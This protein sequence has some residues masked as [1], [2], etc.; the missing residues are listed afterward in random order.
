MSHNVSYL[1]EL[2]LPFSVSGRALPRT[3]RDGAPPA[4]PR[5]TSSFARIR[6]EVLSGSELMFPGSVSGRHCSAGDDGRH[7]ARER[8]SNFFVSSLPCDGTGDATGRLT[9]PLASRPVM[10]GRLP[11]ASAA[12]LTAR[13]CERSDALKARGISSSPF[14]RDTGRVG[15]THRLGV[16]RLCQRRKPSSE[17]S[18]PAQAGAPKLH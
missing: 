10:A 5:S 16:V 14:G 6:S 15:F 1:S 17:E 3:G 12:G 18:L 2:T 9:L 11:S 8:H 7:G 13:G 4:S